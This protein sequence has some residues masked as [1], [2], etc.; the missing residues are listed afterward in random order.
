MP[1]LQMTRSGVVTILVPSSAIAYQG[2]VKVIANS[3]HTGISYM[4]NI[5]LHRSNSRLTMV[6][7]V[8]LSSNNIVMTT[9]K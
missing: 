5:T 3:Q 7:T 8:I 4:A 2:K 6:Y 1:Q 9:R